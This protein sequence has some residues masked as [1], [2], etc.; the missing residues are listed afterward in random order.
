[1]TT[2]LAEM[3]ALKAR[4]KATWEAGDYG[5]FARYLEPGALEFLGR[6]QI[7]PGT[8]MLDVACGAGQI[9][10]PAARAG[11]EVIGLDIAS[12]LVAQARAHAREAGLDVEF[13]EG[14]AEDLPYDNG[15]FDLVVSLMGAMFAP[16]PERVA[17]E[18]LRVCRPG[19]RVVMANWTPEGHVGQMFRIMGAYA[20]PSPLMA[21]PLR[22]GDEGT[23]HERLLAAQWLE[24]T[25][26]HYPIRYPFPPL[27]V[28]E[29]FR[30]YYGPANRA[31]AGLDSI[32]KQ[33]LRESLV[34]L[35][36]RNNL[37]DDGTTWVQS[38]YLEVVA[39]R[40]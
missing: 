8:R 24:T 39:T 28:V 4:L 11:A 5:H 16:R 31:F 26:R 13:E 3:D 32:D 20:P 9:S 23:V 22:W 30:E 7:V 25:R 18:L 1:M 35:W 6:L 27:Q 21:S 17:S 2:A 33:D 36:T 34:E 15:S 38:E 19:G 14:D 37:A 40:G 29:F 12:N 10:I